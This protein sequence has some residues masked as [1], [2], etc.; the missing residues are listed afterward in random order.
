MV[1]NLA[2][3]RKLFIYQGCHFQIKTK[4]T[5]KK[6]IHL[7]PATKEPIWIKNILE[8]WF[9]LIRIT[10]LPSRSS[11]TVCVVGTGVVNSIEK[12]S[13]ISFPAVWWQNGQKAW[14]LF[15]SCHVLE[16]KLNFCCCRWIK[17]LVLRVW[18]FGVHILDAMSSMSAD[19]LKVYYTQT[20]ILM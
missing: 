13:K 8:I 9:F 7:I 1:R 17:Y 18:T 4:T 15:K 19:K 12:V 16:G 11:I 6:K 14:K 20:V 2:P 5:S 3:W 10:Y